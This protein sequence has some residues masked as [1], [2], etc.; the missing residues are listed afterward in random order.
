VDAIDISPTAIAMAR[1]FAAE[2]DLRINY[3]VG[4]ICAW[5]APKGTY[6]LIVDSF[7]LH[8][9]I[10]DADRRQALG[11]ACRML[12][13][14]G[15]FVVGSV[16]FREFRDHGSDRFDPDAGIVFSRVDGNP[17]GYRDVTQIDGDWYY[18]RHRHLPAATIAR[19]LAA[20]GFTI[21]DQA[22]DS[23]RFLCQPSGYIQL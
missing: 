22:A 4:D 20:A 2:R 17:T 12:R 10:T 8:R 6:D 11:N 16:I 14:G 5:T 18:A 7:C 1:Q 9:I 15:Y 21:L 13:P 3:A 23:G 19:E